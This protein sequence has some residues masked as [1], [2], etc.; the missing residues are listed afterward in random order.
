M[1]DPPT[2]PPLDQAKLTRALPD[3]RSTPVSYACLLVAYSFA[4]TY[5]QH[6]QHVQT[7]LPWLSINGLHCVDQLHTLR[8]SE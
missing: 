2:T 7:V 8:T 5:A 3:S 1:P 6:V 4:D